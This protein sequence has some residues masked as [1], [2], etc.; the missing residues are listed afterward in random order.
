[1]NQSL[2]AFLFLYSLS[3]FFTVW[4]ENNT[5]ATLA[6]A[7]GILSYSFLI[8]N[9]FPKVSFRKMTPLLA[10]SGTIMILVNGYLVY[11][12]VD[13]IQGF[14]L[15]ELHYAFVILNA[16]TLFT[17]G[18]L[19]FL[20]NHVHST[21]ASLVFMAFVLFIIFSEVMRAIAYYDFAYGNIPAF[22]ARGLMIIGLS[23]LVVYTN[24]KKQASEQ[25][26]PRIF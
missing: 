26:N 25:L 9:V 21:R 19:A 15:S 13:K 8:W 10:I 14:A 22:V 12:L 18:C 6:M 17:A 11:M 23:F 24:L 5:M 16:A 3:G 2:F 1:M 7:T 20:Y 4:Y